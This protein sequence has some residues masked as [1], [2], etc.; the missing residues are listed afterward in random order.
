MLE[1]PCRDF[2]NPK[3][4]NIGTKQHLHL[5]YNGIYCNRTGIHLKYVSESLSELRQIIIDKKIHFF[6]LSV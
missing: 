2:N 4:A 1:C 5:K 6:S 3:K